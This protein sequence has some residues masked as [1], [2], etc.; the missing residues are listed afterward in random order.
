MTTTLI[1]STGNTIVLK[2]LEITNDNTNCNIMSAG[3]FWK[4][5]SFLLMSNDLLVATDNKI[6]YIPRK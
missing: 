6:N 5:D 1:N 3:I 4:N 2:E